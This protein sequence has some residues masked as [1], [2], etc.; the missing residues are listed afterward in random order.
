MKD[1][2]QHV[3]NGWQF[4]S[5]KQLI[6]LGGESLLIQLHIQSGKNRSGLF[7]SSDFLMSCSFRKLLRVMSWFSLLRTR[8]VG[9][10]IGEEERHRR[11]P[12]SSI[13]SC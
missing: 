3:M 2:I 10:V 13:E 7:V 6:R 9:P 1:I 8:V 12:W 11:D 4:D 5:E